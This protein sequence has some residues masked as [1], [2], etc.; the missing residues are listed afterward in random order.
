MEFA[1]KLTLHAHTIQKED[2][3]TLRGHVL[4]DEEILDVDMAAAM[5]K[6][7][8]IALGRI[9]SRKFAPRTAGRNIFVPTAT[10]AGY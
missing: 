9:S 10:W 2:V 5:L 4:S 3:Q 6:F 1:E 8:R 7:A